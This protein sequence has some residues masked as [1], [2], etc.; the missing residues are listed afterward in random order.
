[1]AEDLAVGTRVHL[2]LKHFDIV[3][4]DIEIR[5]GE[6]T[7]SAVMHD[8]RGVFY[9]VELNRNGKTRF[10][11]AEH[12]RVHRAQPILKRKAIKKW[13]PGLTSWICGVILHDIWNAQKRASLVITMSWETLIAGS[14][15]L[16]LTSNKE[17]SM[18]VETVE[19]VIRLD[20]ARRIQSGKYK[21]KYGETRACNLF[22]DGKPVRVE[23]QVTPPRIEAAFNMIKERMSW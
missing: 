22:K 5:G 15:S 18:C 20:L 8:D 21:P 6:G 1:M 4:H 7:V 14:R 12:L 17:T 3:G 10:A 19:Y 16:K 2:A 13:R 9:A 11:R 23:Y